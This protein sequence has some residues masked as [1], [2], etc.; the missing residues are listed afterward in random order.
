MRIFQASTVLVTAALLLGGTAYAQS[1]GVYRRALDRAE[2]A[3]KESSATAKKEEAMAKQA[4]DPAATTP[5]AKG[6]AAAPA[7]K[8][9]QLNARRDP[10]RTVVNENAPS[11]VQPVC[12]AG[13]RSVLVGSA[14]VNG[15]VKMPNSYIAVVT[16]QNDRTYFLREGNQ[17]CN[18]T[19]LRI[20]SDS[21]VMEE[22]VLDTRGIT[23]KRE[24]IKKIPAEAK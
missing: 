12:G 24:V 1:K 23:T 15:I 3:A 4:Q 18:G 7:G 10:F 6:G 8:G 9:G 16:T 21:V 20:T 13:I 17:L 5:G 19:V 14:E 2:T 11:N 22:D